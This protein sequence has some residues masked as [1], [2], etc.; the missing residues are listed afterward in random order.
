[1]SSQC[2]G[3]GESLGWSGGPAP[4]CIGF[5]RH[6]MTARSTQA[7]LP[8]RLP[9]LGATLAR[10]IRAGRWVFATGLNGAVAGVGLPESVTGGRDPPARAPARQRGGRAPVAHP[11]AGLAAA[12]A[13][14]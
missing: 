11:R 13:G 10:G 8:V 9:R 14:S 12:G 7:I 5:P 2:L 4:P 3:G 6:A 1:M